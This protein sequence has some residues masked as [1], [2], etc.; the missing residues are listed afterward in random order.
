MIAWAFEALVASALLMLLVLVLRGPVR[1]AFG[2]EVAYALWLLPVARM[3]LPPLPGEWQLSRLVSPLL[4]R[5]QETSVVTGVMSPATVPVGASVQ[6]IE[7]TIGGPALRA[8]IVPPTLLEQGANLLPLLGGLWLAGAVLFLLFQLE[9]Y[10]RFCARLRRDARLSVAGPVRVIESRAAHGPLA[11]GIWRKY[12]AFPADFEARYDAEEQALALAHELTHHAR[13]DLVANWVALVMLALHWFNPLAWRAFRAF[14]A[15]QEM[16]C[17]ARVLAGRDQ[18]LRH[19][20]GR[21]IVKSAHGGAV[22]AACHL[23]TINE[24]KGRLRMLSKERVSPGRRW[25]GLA[26]VSA[27]A[28]AGLGLTASGTAAA[29][30]LREQVR[31][32]TGVDLTKLDLPAVAAP[33]APQSPAVG[34][35]PVPPSAAAPAP[36]PVPAPAP[37]AAPQAP[38]APPA[39]AAPEVSDDLP[40]PAPPAPGADATIK[41]QII[42]RTL[43]GRH[44]DV[45]RMRHA[46]GDPQVFLFKRYAGGKD[47]PEVRDGDCGAGDKPLVEHRQEG[48][49][50]IVII[51]SKRIEQAAANASERA[52]HAAE[53]AMNADLMARNARRSALDGVRR[54]RSAILADRSMSEAQRSEALKGIDQAIAELSSER[55]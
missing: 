23:H 46:D 25:G 51:C 38:D 31:V 15:D 14:R 40:P 26:G 10:R 4:A 42:V 12:V 18:A 5:A 53:L 39:P 21:A 50:R 55:D 43:D 49:K 3:V 20:Y 36:A 8:A 48:K 24:L 54:A 27:L 7:V 19:A 32:T 47:M 52:A 2:P 33:A 34:T 9:R 45:R 13:G 22:S 11:F 1:R 6:V 28:L 37:A 29:E 17:D 41:K 16:A 30:H 35:A 44:M